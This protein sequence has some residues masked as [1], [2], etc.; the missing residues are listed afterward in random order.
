MATT[1]S[2]LALHGFFECESG[3]LLWGQMHTL[4]EGFKTKN[5]D[6][7]QGP[8]SKRTGGTILQSD[9]YYR[10]AARPGLWKVERAFMDDN[11][12]GFVV[13]HADVSGTD[14]LKRAATVGIS[15]NQR[16]EN[17]D[18]VYVNR[19][20]WSWHHGGE[21]AVKEILEFKKGSDSDDDINSN[22]LIG[23]RLM[24]VDAAYFDALCKHLRNKRPD[25]GECC[26]FKL[27]NAPSFGIHVSM[28]GTEYELGWLMFSSK[29]HTKFTNSD[30]LIGIVYDGAY[31]AL[32]GNVFKTELFI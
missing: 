17:N 2:I 10:C 5:H 11:E 18:V 31:S 6:S 22:L 25:E 32:E 21:E 27:G 3:E 8:R 4:I 16:H 24:V 1:N 26:E 28:K 7:K 29:Q 30:E 23:G 19:Y 12:V 15:H 14:L 9:F 20:D 13:H